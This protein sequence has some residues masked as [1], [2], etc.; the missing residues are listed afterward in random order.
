MR[1]HIA[2][3]AAN[4]LRYCDTVLSDEH[5]KQ[6]KEDTDIGLLAEAI[7]KNGGPFNE[8]ET[9]FLAEAIR[10]LK[11]RAFRVCRLLFLYL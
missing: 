8:K 4:I 1:R 6:I 7:L 3:T 11:P 5:C 2:K 9:R 10:L